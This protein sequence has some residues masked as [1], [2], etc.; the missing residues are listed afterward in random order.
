V[1]RSAGPEPGDIE[2]L[3]TSVVAGSGAQ[4]QIA[5]AEEEGKHDGSL[6][7]QEEIDEGGADSNGMVHVAILL[8]FGCNLLL[9]CMKAW[10]A[11]V[12]GSMAII[13]STA[14]SLLDLLSGAVLLLAERAAHTNV[15]HY[16]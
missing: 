5:T 16:K 14:D 1:L 7:H 9:L 12:T 2:L 15:N 13:A 6:H 8:S 11:V 4:D 10:M 3:L